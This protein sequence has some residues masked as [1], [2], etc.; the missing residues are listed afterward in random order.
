MS[1]SASSTRRPVLASLLMSGAALFWALNYQVASTVLAEMTPVSLTFW[2]WLIACGPLFVLAWVIERPDWRIVAR[3]LPQLVLLS[4]LGLLGYNLLLYWAL[5]FTTPIGAVVINAANPALIVL[6]AVVLTGQ[7]V[8]RRGVLGIVVSL[9]GV[10]LVLSQG[11]PT[12]LVRDGVNTGQLFM[13]GAITVWSLYTIWG[14]VDGVGPITST[15]VQS[16]IAVVALSPWAVSG[17]APLPTSQAGVLGLLLIAALP[18]VGSY[19]LWNTATSMVSSAAAAVHLNLITVFVVII[20]VFR[21]QSLSLADLI[22]AT[23]II[24]GVVTTSLAAAPP[25]HLR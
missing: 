11:S 9:A 15:A 3:R 16:A 5:H 22:G 1:S 20:G 24:V 2:R 17:H 19:V 7:S 10:L 4:G 21:G 14:R 25:K 18:S 23:L 6:L 12:T 8:S 13:L